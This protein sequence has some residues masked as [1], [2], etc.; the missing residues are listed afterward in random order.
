MSP[1]SSDADS[2]FTSLSG[3]AT[4]PL[5]RVAVYCGSNDGARPEYMECARALGTLMAGRGLTVVYGGGRVG[6]MGALADAALA[7]GGEVIGV[8]PHGLVQREVAH[9]GLTALR[10]VESM[11]ER[12]AIIAELA[13][14]F[15]TLPGGLGTLEEFFETWTWAQL[16]VHR[17][18]MGLFDVAGYWTPLVALL[19]HIEAEGFLRGKPREWL[20]VSEDASSMLTRLQ[21]FNAPTVRRW[22]RLGDT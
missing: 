19:D 22:L 5:Q 1:A 16:G 7:A 11:H 21:T 10:V 6:L 12:K 14:A 3:P 2:A 20:V 18:P 4:A 13:D 15:I 17:K 8:M 9:H